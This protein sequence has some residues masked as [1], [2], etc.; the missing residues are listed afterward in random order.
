MDLAEVNPTC[1]ALQLH[2]VMLGRLE[3]E[4]LATKHAVVNRAMQALELTSQLDKHRSLSAEGL[5]C[6]KPDIN[7]PPRYADLATECQSFL[8]QFEVVVFFAPAINLCH[9]SLPSHFCPLSPHRSGKGLESSHL[10]IRVRELLTL[11]FV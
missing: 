10:G 6:P 4:L 2:G 8:T 1:S 7:N 9:R 11:C 3:Q 5:Q